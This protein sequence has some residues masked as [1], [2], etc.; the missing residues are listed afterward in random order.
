[1]AARERA[2]LVTREMLDQ[3]RALLSESPKKKLSEA[4]TKAYFIQPLELP[5]L[6]GQ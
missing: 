3:L 1:M 5:R 4:D 6:G 2:K